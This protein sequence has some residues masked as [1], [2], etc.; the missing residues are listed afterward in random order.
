MKNVDG[1]VS[2][3]CDTMKRKRGKADET[4][5]L[6]GVAKLSLSRFSNALIA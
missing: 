5:Q 1:V 3:K 2:K 4:V 6:S